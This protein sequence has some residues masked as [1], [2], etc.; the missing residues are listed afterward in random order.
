VP[1]GRGQ[2]LRWLRWEFAQRPFRERLEFATHLLDRRLRRVPWD[3]VGVY[4]HLEQAD[5]A[6]IPIDRDGP[7]YWQLKSENRLTLKMAMGLPVIATPI[8]AYE[9]IVESGRN[10][11]F[12]ASRADWLASL[13][14]LR[15]PALR[16]RIGEQARA[17]VLPR[18][19]MEAQA[20]ALIGTLRAALERSPA[21]AP[22]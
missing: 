9:P 10:A 19:S 5:I 18:F 21:Q 4:S 2:R 17:S 15:D 8:P 16:R 1:T 3:P 12:A 20:Q 7:A 13:E 22:R 14:A 11:F 6:I